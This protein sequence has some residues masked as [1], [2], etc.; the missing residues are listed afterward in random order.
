[1]CLN[2]YIRQYKLTLHEYV[3][4]LTWITQLAP[5]SEHTCL[6]YKNQLVLQREIIS[7]CTEIHIKHINALRG[8]EVEFMNVKLGST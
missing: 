1:M 3:I 4:R 8:P 5:R 7:V 2:G 6:R